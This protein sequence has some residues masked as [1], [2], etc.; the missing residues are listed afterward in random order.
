MK[1]NILAIFLLLISAN[2][3]AG[4]QGWY[5]PYDVTTLEVSDNGAHFSPGGTSFPSFGCSGGISL[6]HFESGTELA[7][8]VISVGLTAQSTGRKVKFYLTGGCSVS[9][10][11]KAVAIQSNPTW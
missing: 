11:I 8:R 9:G 6:I 4:T 5:G 3:V 2:V 7:N 1:K 10:Y